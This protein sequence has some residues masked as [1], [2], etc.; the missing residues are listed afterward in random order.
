MSSNGKGFLVM[1]ILLLVLSAVSLALALLSLLPM[2]FAPVGIIFLLL[3]GVFA[4]IGFYLRARVRREAEIRE[5]GIDG[6][7]KLINWWIIGKSGGE[8]DA[9]EYCRFELE[10]MVE[11]RTPYKVEHRQL[12]PFGV[13]SHLSKGMIL[14]V[15]VHRE[16]P[17]KVILDWDRDG[18][19]A[20][21]GMALPVDVVEVMKGLM[22]VNEKG[23]L[24]ERLR[25]LEDAYKEELVSKDEYERKRI[26][27]LKNI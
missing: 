5:E 17:G 15:K 23:E 25:E 26:E 16:K 9:V 10:V 3:G 2:E 24:K 27:I 14:P 6:K 4:G 12:V 8:L 11:G 7:A 1:G 22:P 18:G 20:I 19:W 13:Y 21:S